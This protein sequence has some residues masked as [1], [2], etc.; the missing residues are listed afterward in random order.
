MNIFASIFSGVMGTIM[1]QDQDFDD[2]VEIYILNNEK[3]NNLSISSTTCTKM[4]SALDIRSEMRY[5]LNKCVL[6]TTL[7]KIHAELELKSC[8]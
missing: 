6:C 2:L 7:F 4:V 8:F 5:F 1:V 3:I